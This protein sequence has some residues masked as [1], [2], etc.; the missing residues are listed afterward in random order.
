VGD[1]ITVKLDLT[2]SA[3]EVT[4]YVN[5]QS[6]GIAFIGV[7]RLAPLYF[8][9]HMNTPNDAMEILGATVSDS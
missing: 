9:I 3:G 5:G 1:V 4:Y 6:M 8:G 2:D 7:R